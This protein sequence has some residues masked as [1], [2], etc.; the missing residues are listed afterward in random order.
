MKSL[1]LKCL[2]NWDVALVGCDFDGD[3]VTVAISQI[4]PA[5]LDDILGSEVELKEAKVTDSKTYRLRVPN[6]ITAVY[7]EAVYT[8]VSVI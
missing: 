5:K 6:D 8:L 7:T 1:H 2:R 3:A 4:N